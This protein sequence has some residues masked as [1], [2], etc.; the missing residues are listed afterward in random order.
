MTVL[1]H[2]K[3][4]HLGRPLLRISVRARSRWGSC[5]LSGALS[6]SWRLI[7]APPAVLDYVVAHEVA[8]LAERGHGPEFWR[9]V[10]RLTEHMVAGRAWLR[11]HGRELFRYG[12]GTELL[13]QVNVQRP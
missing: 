3:A 13:L 10:A 7:L 4:E 12:C 9:T 5:S 1:A 6:F 11:R 2:A 8:H